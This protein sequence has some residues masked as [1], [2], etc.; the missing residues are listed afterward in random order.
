MVDSEISCVR[1]QNLL[2][3]TNVVSQR[4]YCI[5]MK[6]INMPCFEYYWFPYEG[7]AYKIKFNFGVYAF[8]GSAVM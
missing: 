5:K 7:E 6:V 4:L 1:K 3:L 2:N 8:L